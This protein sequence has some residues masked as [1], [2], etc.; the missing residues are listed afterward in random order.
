MRMRVAF[1]VVAITLVFGT[2]ARAQDFGVLESAETIN[3]GNIKL[4]VFPLFVFPDGGGTDFRLPISIGV[5]V[6]NSFD[7]EGRVAFSDD[8]TFLGGDGEYWFLKN[9]PLDVSFRGGL[10]WGF[11]DGE[12]GDTFG[13]DVSLLGS[14]PVAPRLELTGALDLA[15]NSMDI[16]DDRDGFTTVHLVPGIEVAINEDLDFLAEFGLGLSDASSHYAAFGIAFYFR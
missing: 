2:G 12:I 3:R 6:G 11:V 7:L 16:G 15:F 9:A 5:G 13:V 4:G 8:V 14:A 1:S 10:H